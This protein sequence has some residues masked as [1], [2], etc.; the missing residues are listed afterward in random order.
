MATIRELLFLTGVVLMCLGVAVP[1]QADSTPVP[2]RDEGMRP[3]MKLW[4]RQA[5]E[6][7]TEALPV[8]N[9][10]LGAMVFGK[11]GEERIQLN[12]DTVWTGG[13]YDPSNPDARAALPEVQR[14]VFEG[15]Y[16]MAQYL[17]GLRM[18]GRPHDQMKYQPLGDLYLTFLGHEAA[19][20]YRRELD[21]DSAVAAVTYRVGDVTFTREVFASP[22]DQVIVVRLTADRPGSISFSARLTGCKNT[23]YPG[24]ETSSSEGLAPDGLVSRGTTATYLGVEGRVRYAAQLRA[25]NEG[26]A[27]SVEDDTL[28]VADA[29]AATL[30]LAAATDLATYKD[31]SGD[32]DARVRKYLAGVKGKPYDRILQDHL[33]EHRRLFRRVVLD[34]G[35]T[36]GAP[37]PTDERL[38][39]VR[40]GGDDPA[41]FALLFQFGR[42]LLISSSRPGDQPAN[43]QGIWNQD[44]NPAWDSKYTT[45]INLQMNYWPVEV[46]NLSECFDPLFRLVS[47]LTESGGRVAK[48]DYGAHGWVL[49]HNTD[50]WRAAAPINGPTWGTWPC[51]GAWLCQNLWEHYLFCSDREYLRR[52]YPILKGA[53]EFFLDTLVEEP[54][55]RWLVTCPSSSP[56]NFPQRE[57]NQRYL[58]EF[59]NIWLPGTSICAGPTIDMQILRDLFDHCIKAAQTLGV[60]EEFRK[61]IRVTRDRLAP[62][63]IG[64]HGNLQEWLEDWGDLEPEHRHLSHLY[65]LFPSDQISPRKTPGLA[66]AAKKSLIARGEGGPGWSTAWKIGLW[67]RLLDAEHAYRAARMTLA[68]NTYPDLFS[69]CWEPMQVDGNFGYTAGVAE[70]LLQSQGGE[71]AFLPALPKQWPTGAFRGLRARG[72]LEVDL[73]WQDG[74]ALTAALL[75]SA[76][77][78]ILLRPP[79]GQRITSV[80]DSAQPIPAE[81]EQDGAMLLRFK[82]G[83]TYALEFD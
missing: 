54:T 82:Q 77:G 35:T 68:D 52:L 80:R 20:D 70:M 71:L 67:A 19:A 11:T 51:G 63:Q 46:G 61:K 3:N 36:D 72:G 43:L 9:G 55:H 4:Y 32:P 23:D 28:T 38:K 60:D 1:S 33:T 69:H 45:N 79:A 26:G 66:E 58:D 39:S 48:V 65:G 47:D 62:M 53:A 76:D 42:Y 31:V 83:H 37:L 15:K 10:R 8:G 27:I 34:L 7:W 5:A 44:M 40:E 25:F 17:F 56:E 41:L 12:E 73:T 22:I 57:G 30:I 29:D 59:T 74:K 21:L 49:H 24:D 2:A 18:M 14:L 78:D 16:M 50:L 13:P 64:K 81:P 75:A 6:K